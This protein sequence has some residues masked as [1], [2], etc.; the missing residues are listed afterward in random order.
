MTRKDILLAMLAAAAGLPYTP[1]QL[2]KGMFLVTTNV[3]ALV[4][5]G[6]A[7]NFVP[8]D[9]GPFDRAVYDEASAL[10][11]EEL[12]DIQP[13]GFGQWNVYAASTEGVEKGNEILARMSEPHRNYVVELSRWVRAQSFTSLVKSI[14]KAYPDMRANSIF[15]SL[16]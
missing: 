7:F 10:Q 15:R 11:R 9:Y 3:P 16:D 4:N 2:Q 12:A 8:Y 13:S 1:A 5:E 6:P 14:Y